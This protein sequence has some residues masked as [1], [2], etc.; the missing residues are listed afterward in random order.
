MQQHM[1]TIQHSTDPKALKL[2]ICVNCIIVWAAEPFFS[3][4]FF[5]YI[6]YLPC[7]PWYICLLMFIIVR[8]LDKLNK[9]QKLKK[10]QQIFVTGIKRNNVWANNSTSNNIQ[11]IWI[12]ILIF[13]QFALCNDLTRMLQFPIICI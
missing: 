7:K 12:I 11:I 9:F 1:Q 5:H 13:L 8:L 3:F 10:Q 6:I 4:L 2:L